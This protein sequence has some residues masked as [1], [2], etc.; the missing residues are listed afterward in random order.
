MDHSQ[1]SMLL[2]SKKFEGKALEVMK[3]GVER[4]PK[5]VKLE[6]RMGG[7]TPEVVTL[8]G[9]S[10][11]QGGMMLYTSGTTNRPASSALFT[12]SFLAANMM[13]ERRSP[14]AIRCDCTS[15]VSHQS[16]ELL[17]F[18]S[19]ASCTSLASYPWHYK[20]CTRTPF[21]RFYNRVSLSLQCPISLAPLRSSLPPKSTQ[22]SSFANYILYSCAN[23]LQPTTHNILRPH[24]RLSKGRQNRHFTTEPEAQYLRLS[25]TAYANEES[26]EYTLL[27]QR[28]FRTVRYDGS[29]HGALLW[30]PL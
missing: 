17:T 7:A 1:A 24:P 15:P 26:V 29:R 14:P 30:S 4:T 21:R 11:G 20:C 19:P 28:S 9:C 5:H 12:Y 22:S 16:L 13:L 10:E 2:S 6:K 3:Q 8:E 18:G 23:S 27:W 25:C